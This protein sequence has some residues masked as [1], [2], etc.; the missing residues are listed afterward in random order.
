M[1]R[2][3]IIYYGKDDIE[4][5]VFQSWMKTLGF[6]MEIKSV[7]PEIFDASHLYP[8]TV[9]VLALAEPPARLI[10]FAKEIRSHADACCH[11]IL[12]LSEQKFD[13]DVPAAEVFARPLRLSNVAK[14]IQS[15]YLQQARFQQA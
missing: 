10:E 3:M 2:P 14:R 8:E 9:I 5:D 11:P 6:H 4:S 1:V 15:T 13:L 7:L 12:I